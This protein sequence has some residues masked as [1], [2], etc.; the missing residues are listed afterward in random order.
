MASISE[1]GGNKYRV[2]ISDGF[3]ANG[4]RN[5]ITKTIIAKTKTEAKKKADKLEVEFRESI[6][7]DR[8]NWS[9]KELVEEWRKTQKVDIGLK[10][11]ERYEQ[12]IQYSLLDM[13]G[14]MKVK[15]IASIHI[16]RYMA[17]LKSDG[18]RRDGKAGGY[19]EQTQ[20]HHYSL[21]RTLL[22]KA[23]KWEIIN[24]N[25]CN[26]VDIPRVQKTEA[27]YYES[28]HI[29]ILLK[30][31]EESPV[32]YKVFT[33]IALFSGCRRS[34]ILGMEWKDFDLKNN[35]V[36]IV[37]TSQ[38]VR[39]LGIVTIEKTKN[40]SSRRTIALPS[41]TIELLK[42]YKVVQD[43]EKEDKGESWVETDR[44]F[45]R[46]NGSPMHPS[47][48]YNWLKKILKK[49]NLEDINIHGFRH[50]H[51]SILI[52]DGMDIVG[53]S[54]RVGHADV[55]T[56]LNRYAHLMKKTDYEGANKLE[57]FYENTTR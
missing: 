35:T 13:F 4:K 19:A 49:H 48:P 20:K 40:D 26:K 55:S 9:F 25:P 17:W 32:K 1:L 12:I 31:I 56:T 6:V 36:S 5:R 37:R 18:V 28:E 43:R 3:K 34:E 50:T 7:S 23:V 21:L 15:D 42:E 2:I 47:T 10:T 33:H 24:I 45:I 54:R 51:V 52:N 38:D 27:K 57:K 30:L 53:V 44:I 14:K 39:G 16:D 11:A 41:G 8:S 46:A 22:N 29:G